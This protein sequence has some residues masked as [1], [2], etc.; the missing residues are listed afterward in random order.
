[1]FFPFF[2]NKCGILLGTEETRITKDQALACG[3]FK[4]GSFDTVS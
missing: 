2:I 3:T 1:L 4:Q